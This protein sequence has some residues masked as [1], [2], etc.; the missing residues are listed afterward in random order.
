MNENINNTPV[1]IKYEDLINELENP[2]LKTLCNN[3]VST[4]KTHIS[5]VELGIYS[6]YAYKSD[7][8]KV[9]ID[10]IDAVQFTLLRMDFSAITFKL[11][12][13]IQNNLSANIER[14]DVFN[15]KYDKPIANETFLNKERL[16][17][18]IDTN[19]NF[20]KMIGISDSDTPIYIT[21]MNAISTCCI[22]AKLLAQLNDIV[23]W[24]MI[25]LISF[26]DNTENKAII[27]IDSRILINVTKTDKPVM[28]M[29]NIL[30]N[31]RRVNQLVREVRINEDWNERGLNL[32]NHL[33]PLSNPCIPIFITGAINSMLSNTVHNDNKTEGDNNEFKSGDKKNN[34]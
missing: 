13:E 25:K 3:I 7:V 33:E 31:T 34:L 2:L 16:N 18:I 23:T 17:T 10:M 32:K 12:F 21:Y 1:C 22:C 8:A 14:L 24:D 27:D 28:C 9:I 29:T 30:Q 5:M 26:I 4:K 15:G 20:N 6:D 11:N 19:P